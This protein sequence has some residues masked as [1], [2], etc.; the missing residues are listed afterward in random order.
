MGEGRP[1]KR[2][3]ALCLA[4]CLALA[5]SAC[6]SAQGG[7]GEAASA[8]S[9]AFAP[10]SFR[11]VVLDATAETLIVRTVSGLEYVLDIRRAELAVEPVVG[12]TVVVEYEGDLT[13]TGRNAKVVR[14]SQGEASGAEPEHTG[15]TVDGVVTGQD[16]EL[17]MLR[18]RD[19]SQY[20][21]AM[22]NTVLKLNKGFTKDLWVR[23]TFD[24]IVDYGDTDEAAVQLVTELADEP[25]TYVMSAKLRKYDDEKDTLR[26]AT[27]DGA[28]REISLDG[29]ETVL[30]T[31]F[32][33]DSALYIYYR[34]LPGK[35]AEGNRNLQVVRVA[36]QRV[37]VDE[38]LHLIV[39]DYD[40]QSGKLTGHALDGRTFQ[41]WI[42]GSLLEEELRA[43]GGPGEGDAVRVDYTGAL[44]GAD[45]GKWT[46]TGVVRTAKSTEYVSSVLG[47][48]SRVGNTFALKAEDGRT[49]VFREQE[50]GAVPESIA[51]GDT[52]R[53]FFT[54]WLGSEDDDADTAHATLTRVAYALD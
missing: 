16:G 2:W 10:Q 36:D 40:A 49:L 1:M 6:G 30:P 47:T 20:T 14:I 43:D 4:L 34:W 12:M 5:L 54:G 26:F 29:V 53:A 22:S 11:G 3:T 7:G 28:V 9:E 45:T 19:G 25:D 41:F 23:V 31:G 37:G 21:F 13:G 38:R 33:D 42:K 44:L 48:V 35:D 15:S 24:G 18:T 39:E 27:D 51:E 32:Q 17:T 8:V 52:V 50:E 46:V